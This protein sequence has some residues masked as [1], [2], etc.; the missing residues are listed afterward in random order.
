MA[1]ARTMLHAIIAL[2]LIALGGCGAK[3]GVYVPDAGVVNETDSGVDAGVDAGDGG[4]PEECIEIPFDGGPVDLALDVEAQVGR[5]DVV[6]L[7]DVTASMREELDEVKDR[8]QDRI[9]PAIDSAIPDAELAVAT[10]ADFPIRGLYGG[11]DDLPFE[12]RLPMTDDIT[13]VQAALGSISLGNGEDPPESQVEALYQLVT[14]EGR[15]P[16]VSASSGCPNGGTGYACFRSDALPVILLFTDAPFHNGPENAHPYDLRNFPGRVS[17]A[18]YSEAVSELRRIDARVIGFDSG[19]GLAGDHLDTL[20]ADTD[21]LDEFGRPL[22]LDIG[23]RAQRLGDSVVDAIETFAGSVVQDIGLELRDADPLDGVD[24][25]VFIESVELGGATPASGVA[26]LDEENAI[27]LG[28][29]AGTR[30]T[31]TLVLRN[32][33]IAPGEGAQR[34]RLYAVFTADGTRRIARREIV[35]V[36]PGADGSG[37]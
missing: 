15:E 27:Y 16:Y 3:T 32:D 8:L 29:S 22:V 25:T 19:N 34:F 24:P 31:W 23:M 26:G 2:G 18:T 35:L 21:T 14:G 5:A 30:L 36:V 33:A 6:F 10:F 17:P 7:L 1:S 20:A 4:L 11:D 13:A 9:A 12:L 28:A 37:C